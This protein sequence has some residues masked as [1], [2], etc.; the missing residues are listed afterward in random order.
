[1]APAAAGE[2]RLS[3]GAS[4]G[5]A[6]LGRQSLGRQSS[7]GTTAVSDPRPMGDKGF[8]HDCIRDLITFLTENGYN[9][10]LSPK[11]LTAPTNK[12][13][14][15]IFQFLYHQIDPNYAFS[16]KAEDEIPVLFKQLRYPYAVQKSAIF[17]CGSPHNWPKLLAALV[18]L[19]ELATV[20][21]RVDMAQVMYRRDDGFEQEASESE[22]F[23]D[24][25]SKAYAAFMIGDE[26]LELLENELASSFKQRD[27]TIAYEHK[28]LEAHNAALR[29]E[30]QQ[31]QQQPPPLVLVQ[32]RKSD[33]LSDTHKFK[34]L[35]ANLTAHAAKLQARHEQCVAEKKQAEARLRTAQHDHARL[36]ETFDKQALTPEDVE[37]LNGNRAKLDEQL[38]HALARKAE[39]EKRAWKTEMNLAKVVKEL[40]D[41]VEAYNAC[42]ADMALQPAIGRGLAQLNLH[43]RV[44]SHNHEQPLSQD[45]RAAV[46]P[47]L[48]GMQD[49]LE[50]DARKMGGERI[51][52]E[53]QAVKVAEAAAEKRDECAVLGR[54]VGM[55]EQQYAQDKETLEREGREQAEAIQQVHAELVH[56]RQHISSAQAEEARTLEAA[57]QETEELQRRL[58]QEKEFFNKIMLQALDIVTTHKDC[59]QRK[60]EDL[61][62]C[63]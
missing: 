60:L 36:Q 54:K 57:Q 40:E 4:L 61:K 19:V 38:A 37:R 50:A 7:V 34:E 1:M 25:L 20:S 9:Q 41:C 5:R 32:Q 62:S 10:P 27:E 6:S 48:R 29:A 63:I 15:R 11:L 44:D 45:L 21:K 31:L 43:L 13:F 16:D 56:A 24:Y 30:L 8:R 39:A 35:I 3:L 17:S 2:E 42:M 26:Q 46:H 12:D 59:V 22:I 23:F 52:V 58:L 14:I 53:E 33:F 28:R 49:R 51:E 47:V 18:W 55:V